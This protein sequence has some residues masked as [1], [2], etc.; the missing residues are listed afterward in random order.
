MILSLAWRNIWR[1]KMR[2][3]IIMMSVSLGLFA[4][5]AVMA[6]YEGMMVIR[7]RTVIDEETGH[8]QIQHPGFTDEKEA[9]FFLK[10]PDHIIKKIKEIKEVQEITKRV[11]TNGMLTTPTGT[12]GVQIIGIDPSTEYSYS[13]L[14][15]KMKEGNLLDTRKQYQ[16]IIGKKIADKMK[17]KIGSKLVLMFNDTTNNLVSSAYRVAGIYQST[18]TALDARLIYTSGKELSELLGLPDQVH[19]IG[20]K[21]KNDKDLAGVTVRLKDLLP[22]YSVQTWKEL[23]PETEFMVSTVDTYSYVIMII[24]MIAL[25]FGILNTMLMSVVE[26]TREIGMIAALGMSKVRIFMLI[27]LETIFLTLAGSPLGISLGLVTTLYFNKKGLDLSGM[28]EDMM[29]SYGFKTI[30]YPEFPLENLIP[31]LSIVIIT[32]LLSSLIPAIKA[33]Q[34][35]PIEALRQ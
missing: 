6:L 22:E 11:V 12:A 18:N 17:L 26:R 28:G 27:L 14:R 13:S 24:I 19:Q 30:I 9:A 4:G 21:L 2:S 10:S 32:S 23:A 16:A 7:I 31:V 20:L 8:I 3:L 5:V 1:H 29:G 35:K 34:M 33:I 25:A 15:E